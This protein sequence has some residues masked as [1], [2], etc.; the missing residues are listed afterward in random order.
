[1]EDPD[2][3]L[4]GVLAPQPGKLS[5][6]QSGDFDGGHLNAVS[7]PLRVVLGKFGSYRRCFVKYDGKVEGTLS[8]R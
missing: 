7:F 1:M 3:L 8:A 4:P 6:V 5:V 2:C